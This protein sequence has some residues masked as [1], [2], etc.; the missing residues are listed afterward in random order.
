[1]EKKGGGTGGTN[2]PAKKYAK[3]RDDGVKR[4]DEQTSQH[5]DE[6]KDGKYE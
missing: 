1:M 6:K 2:F 4:S 5:T 3:R